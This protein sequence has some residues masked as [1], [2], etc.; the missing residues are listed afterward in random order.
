VLKITF[1]D[2]LKL[3]REENGMSM[4]ELIIAIN[5]RFPGTLSDKSIVSRYES[6][7]STP[8]KIT[9]VETIAEFFGVTMAYMMGK[10]DSKYG[11]DEICKEIPMLGTIA[12]GIP[13]ASQEDKLGSEIVPISEKVEFC[14][15]VKGSSMIGARIFDGDTVFIH[16]QEEVEN[17]EIAAVQIDG[18]EAT[19]KRFYKDGGKVTLHS[20]NPTIPDMVYTAKDKKMLK[21]LGKVKYVKFEAR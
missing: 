21:I 13:I 11:D 8:K 17:G 12:A 7:T 19:L 6:N 18:E 15:K 3:L 2:R 1:G 4:D 5:K 20:E 10:S 9:T 14:L 16:Q